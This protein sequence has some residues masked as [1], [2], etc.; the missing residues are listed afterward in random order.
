MAYIGESIPKLGFGLMRLPMIGEDV[1]IEQTKQMVDLFLEQGFTYF[2]T[3]YGYLNGK[4]EEA[5]RIALVERYP[6]SRFQLATKLPAWAGAKSREEARQMFW[7][8]LERTGAGYF[9]FYLMHNLGD[10]RTDVFEKY[11][12]WSFLQERKREG[13][14]RSLGFSFHDS[15]EVLERLLTERYPDADF[16]QLQI[17]YADWESPS[18]QSR[19]CYETARRHGKPVVIMEPVKGGSLATLPE[20]GLQ[21]LRSVHPESSPASWAVR[22]AASLE[23]VITVLSGMSNLSQLADNVSYMKHFKPLDV[24]ERAAI[25]QVRDI[26]AA[27]PQ[28]PCTRCQYCVKGCPQGVAIP[29]IFRAM[30]NYL[31]YRNLPGALG[32]YAW[33]THTGGLASKCVQCGQCEAVC[34]QH[35]SIIQEL[36]RARD[37]LEK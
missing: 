12:I 7:T 32:N 3:A 14:I 37:L 35:I 28:I 19:L 22:F 31:I 11:E 24:V 1:D 34:P 27:V 10:D 15:A 13:L 25:G 8:S 21:A 30:N 23:G 29:G 17:N 16:V 9:D 20:A 2:D 18:V 4:S 33:E 5:A 36:Q 26:L 6:R